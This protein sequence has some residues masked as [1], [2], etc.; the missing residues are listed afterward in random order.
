MRF[1]GRSA[2]A[3]ALGLLLLAAL[4]GPASAL[5]VILYADGTTSYGFDP[6]D[7]AA[8]IDAGS[9]EPT[10]LSDLGNGF[11]YFDVSTPTGIPGVKGKNKSNP[12]KGSSIWTLTVDEATPA[13]LLQN[14]CLVI[15]GHDPNDPFSY[16]TENVGL[17]IDTDVPWV[18]V[19]PEDGG[20]TY[21]AFLLGDLEAGGTYEIPIEYRV[22]QRLKKK[23]GV[24]IFP[25]YSIA[26]HSVPLPEPSTLVLG[27]GSLAIA[28]VAARR[29]R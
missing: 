14:F 22:G 28:A 12:S 8:A 2:G 20:P 9:A 19:T 3:V 5:P 10:S 26:Y 21:L 17:Q 6:A 24:H 13:E 4:A 15:L 18:L 29:K 11:G 23:H 1:V 7:V 27:L 25:R 16:K